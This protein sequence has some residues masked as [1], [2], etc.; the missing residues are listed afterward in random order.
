MTERD[1]LVP[2]GKRSV[3]LLSCRIA[4]G[5]EV[6][7]FIQQQQILLTLINFPHREW[8]SCRAVRD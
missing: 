3:S 1:L 2:D 4:R 8:V 7:I 6:M 5:E